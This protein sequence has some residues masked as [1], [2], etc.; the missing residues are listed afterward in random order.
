MT[1][2]F[3]E[4]TP[5]IRQK[6]HDLQRETGVSPEALI[7]EGKPKG[8]LPGAQIVRS[9]MT[10]YCTHADRRQLERLIAAWKSLPRL[11]MVKLDESLRGSLRDLIKRSGTPLST[12]LRGQDCPVPERLTAAGLRRLLGGYET[13]VRKDRYDW[14]VSRLNTVIAERKDI[15]DL[16]PE[17]IDALW[18]ERERTGV[19]PT[20]LLSIPEDGVPDGLSVAVVFSWFSETTKSARRDHYEFILSLWTSLP[21]ESAQRF[22]PRIGRVPLTQNIMGQMQAL[23]DKTGLG[24]AAMLRLAKMHRFDI[25]RHAT[26]TVLHRYLTGKVKTVEPEVVEFAKRVWTFALENRTPRVSGWMQ[27]R[28]AAKREARAIVRVTITTARR[29]ALIAE[30]ARSGVGQSELLKTAQDVPTGLRAGLISAWIN[31]YAQ[32]AR[33]DYYDWVLAQW[34][35]LPNA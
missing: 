27:A 12:L 15:I 6:L 33:K 25:P 24:P 16:T 19:N 5:A 29:D 17:R 31:G 1:S 2:D 14:L 30:R 3:C 7:A 11:E 13:L 8:A 34:R 22:G 28:R 23:R 4:I 9:W 35:D 20:V 26:P 21:P 18:R 32:S 10:G